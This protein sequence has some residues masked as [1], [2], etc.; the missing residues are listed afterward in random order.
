MAKGPKCLSFLGS[1]GIIRKRK[2]C[3]VSGCSNIRLLSKP[4]DS[5]FKWESKTCYKHG[6]KGNVYPGQTSEGRRKRNWLRLGVEFSNKEY[7]IL[8]LKQNGKC[9]LCGKPQ[10]YEKRRLAVDH[11]HKTG[12]IRGLLCAKC[13]LCLGWIEGAT[14]LDELKDYLGGDIMSRYG[15]IFRVVSP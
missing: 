6:K 11:N 10:G 9:A 2:R 1:N 12:K 4:S 5:N 13:N 14:S 3:S 7:D 15:D 8:L